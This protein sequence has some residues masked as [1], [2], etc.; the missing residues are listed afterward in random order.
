MINAGDDVVVIGPPESIR[1]FAGAIAPEQDAPS[2]IVI[3]GG[4]EIG[5]RTALLLEQR[6]F[7]PR[8]I[9]RDSKRAQELAEK[10]QQTVVLKSD[11]TD[12]DFL[13]REHVGQ[14]DVFI[15]TLDNDQQNLLA[16]LL[17]DRL[18]ATR[19][20]AV[21]EALEFR[22]LF[23][24]VGVDVAVSPREAV[25]EEITRFTRSRRTENV[26]IIEQDRAEVLEIEI[27]ADSPATDRRIRDIAKEFSGGVVVGAI[28]R[29]NGFVTPRGE[30]VIQRGDHVVVFTEARTVEAV[31]RMF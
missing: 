26:A 20:V 4:S 3:A 27:D 22:D 14:A 16:T 9:E 7:R 6:G 15:A 10:L 11:A 19:T 25:A 29:D 31:L 5:Y 12:M 28:I 13:E 23:E 2:E 18:G 8:L 30:T 21:V 24:A 1:Q 17:A